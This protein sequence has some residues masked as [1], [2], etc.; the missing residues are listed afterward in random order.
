MPDLSGCCA[1]NAKTSDLFST[2]YNHGSRIRSVE[3]VGKKSA[4]GR[5]LLVVTAK[6][7]DLLKEYTFERYDRIRFQLGPLVSAHLESSR[8]TSA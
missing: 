2:V 8:L 6:Y 4:K 7:V 1:P 3:A 5:L